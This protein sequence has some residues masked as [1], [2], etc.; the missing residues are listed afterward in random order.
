MTNNFD[1]MIPALDNAKIRRTPYGRCS[2]YDLIAVVGAKKNPRQVWNDLQKAYPEVVQ[3]TDNFQFPGQGQRETPV[4]DREGWAYIL[5]LLPGVMGHKYRE[6]AAKLVLRYLDADLSLAEEI[7]ERNDDIEQLERH[8]ARVSSIVMRK[9]LISTLSDHG[10]EEDKHF[11]ICTNKTYRG[12]YG[13]DAKGLR[14]KK[15]LPEKANVREHM[16]TSELVEVTFA[17]NLT[18]KKL[19]KGNQHGVIEC[20][21]ECYDMAKRVARFMDEALSI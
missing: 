17:E 18:D 2:V 8:E 3:K 7:V 15:G 10:I 13:M 1:L 6:S 20:S 16:S 12:L 5:G 21:N 9:K 4:I 14:K 19:Q 11:A